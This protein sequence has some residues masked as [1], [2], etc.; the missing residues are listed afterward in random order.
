MEKERKDLT[1]HVLFL[2]HTD[3]DDTQ[4]RLPD[5]TW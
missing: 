3:V 4:R 2:H 1:I 5:K